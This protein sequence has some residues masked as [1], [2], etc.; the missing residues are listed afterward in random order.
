MCGKLCGETQRAL[1]AARGYPA[2]TAAGTRPLVSPFSTGAFLPPIAPL[3]FSHWRHHPPVASAHVALQPP[4]ATA[5]VAAG[6]GYGQPADEVFEGFGETREGREQLV[7]LPARVGR[8]HASHGL[9]G[10]APTRPPRLVPPCALSPAWL[11]VSGNLAAS[12]CRHRLPVR[13][14]AFARVR[15]CVGA[16]GGWERCSP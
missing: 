6:G 11:P 16:L 13:V 10:C 5:L 9:A 1:R 7:V 8:R 12:V 4:V 3:R 2:S 14:R 15:A